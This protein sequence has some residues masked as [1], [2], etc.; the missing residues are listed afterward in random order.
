MGKLFVIHTYVDD[1]PKE[2]G[3][4]HVHY[5]LEDS[6]EEMDSLLRYMEM[7][8]VLARNT[9]PRITNK[10]DEYEIDYTGTQTIKGTR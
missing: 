2:I 6:G 5:C 4:P 10:I 8:R 9:S 1:E 7:C 3:V